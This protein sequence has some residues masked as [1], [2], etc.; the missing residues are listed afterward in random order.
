[1]N[2]SRRHALVSLAGAALFVTNGCAMFR[3]ASE[4]DSALEE[5]DS[6]LQKIGGQSDDRL[7]ALAGKISEQSHGLMGAH[8]EFESEFNRQAA[9]HD[10]SGDALTQLVADYDAN[11]LQLRNEL[12]HSQDEL[13]EIVPNDAWPDVLEVL[14][15]KQQA[16][17]PGRAREG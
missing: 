12:L 10:V 2:F 1:M 14:N 4:L 17:V 15:R 6:L 3:N 5:L 11:R 8:D 16:R 7:A 13:R 9:D